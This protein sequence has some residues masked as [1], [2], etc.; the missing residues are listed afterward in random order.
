MNALVS[1]SIVVNYN[2]SMFTGLICRLIHLLLQLDSLDVY[3]DYELILLR[4]GLG[5]SRLCDWSYKL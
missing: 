3:I 1:F 2:V 4:V 5:S